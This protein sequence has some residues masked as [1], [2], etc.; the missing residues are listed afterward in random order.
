VSTNNTYKIAPFRSGTRLLDEMVKQV[1]L[2]VNDL[3]ARVKPFVLNQF[4]SSTP[5]VTDAVPGSRVIIYLNSPYTYNLTN[6]TGAQDDLVLV[7]L[8]VGTGTVTVKHNSS[9]TPNILLA[10]GVDWAGGPA[11]SLQLLCFNG[12]FYELSRSANS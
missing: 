4:G 3:Y 1:R 2:A 8:N 6:F 12:A 5:D 7:L 10:G 9:T 11:D